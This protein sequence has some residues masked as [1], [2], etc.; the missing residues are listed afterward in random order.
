MTPPARLPP[1]LIGGV[2]LK[3]HRSKRR[4]NAV[5]STQ[6]AIVHKQAKRGIVKLL[7][8]RVCGSVWC[9]DV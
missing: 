3:Y 2:V 7:Y 5:S 9:E 4:G 8:S 1:C 6:Y